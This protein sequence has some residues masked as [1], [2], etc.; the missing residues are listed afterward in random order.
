MKR[1]LKSFFYAMSLKSD[2]EINVV[3]WSNRICNGIS[4]EKVSDSSIFTPLTGASDIFSLNA[5]M[6]A[7]DFF[8]I[9]NTPIF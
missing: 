6:L 8:L 5:I 3:N 7:F 2:L 4:I 1:L 9:I